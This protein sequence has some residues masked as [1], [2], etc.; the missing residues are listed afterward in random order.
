MS[1]LNK[2]VLYLI[3]EGLQDDSKSL[4]SCLMVNRLWCQTV[5]PILWRNPWCYDINYYTKK[6]LF[7]I[8]SSYLSDDVK[9]SLTRQGIQ[10]L[11]VS[12]QLLLFDYLSFC[13]SINVYTLN[14]I[15]SIGSSLSYN[16][17]ILQQEF[18]GIF[19]K[20]FPELKYLDM[21]FIKHQIFYLPEAKLRFESLC[22]LKCDTSIDSSYFHG[23]AWQCQ[24]IQR[25]IIDN[26]DSENDYHGI[27]KLIKVQKNLKY[28]EWNDDYDTLYVP[29]PDQDSYKEI[30]FAIDKKADTIN[31][32]KLDFLFRCPTLYKVLPKFYKLKTLI[33]NIEPLSEEQLKMCVFR[34]LE[35]FRIGYYELKA[36]SIIIENTG[37]HLKKIFLGSPYELDEYVRNFDDDSLIFIRKVYEKCLSIE[38]LSLIFPPS[39]EHFN[40]FEKLLKICQNLKSLLLAIHI[41]DDVLPEEELL[42]ENEEILKILIRSS[43]TNLKEIRFICDV[44]FSLETLEE[45]LEKWKGRPALSILTSNYIYR[46]KNYKKLINKYKNNGVIKDFI[47]DYFEKVVNMDFKI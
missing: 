6:Y 43:P 42:I 36:A 23:L 27:V 44:E 39:K 19:M 24:Y 9:E 25:L 47:C 18:Y 32:L 16:K 7:A 40:E 4:F 17:F 34:D 30:L 14:V 8:I 29:G 20:K 13:R 11:T 31:H 1:K 10:L 5:V 41:N 15:T 26:V 33:V 3:F 12:R 45:F 28:F 2:D 38:Y 37:G 46:E 35:I 22:E 21:R